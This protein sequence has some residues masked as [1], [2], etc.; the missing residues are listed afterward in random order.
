MGGSIPCLES[1]NGKHENEEH[2]NDMHETGTS[3]FQMS[4]QEKQ[5]RLNEFPPFCAGEIASIQS[6]DAYQTLLVAY[7]REMDLLSKWRLQKMLPRNDPTYL[8][9]YKSM[10]S[11]L[12]QADCDRA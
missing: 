10:D 3:W 12:N 11:F 2:E 5:S 4:R 8:G 6:E 1:D 7:D 9:Y